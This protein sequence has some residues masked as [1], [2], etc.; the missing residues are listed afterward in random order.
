MNKL[1]QRVVKTRHDEYG[2]RK[3]DKISVTVQRGGEWKEES[4]RRRAENVAEVQVGN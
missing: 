3:R 2:K 4:T 1:V